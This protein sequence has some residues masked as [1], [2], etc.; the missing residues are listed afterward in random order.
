V[1][2]LSMN[3]FL[4][5]SKDYVSGIDLRSSSKDYVSGIDLRSISKEYVSGLK[6]NTSSLHNIKIVEDDFL[7]EDSRE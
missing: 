6:P 4:G 3:E 7:S 1:R 2:N 5:N